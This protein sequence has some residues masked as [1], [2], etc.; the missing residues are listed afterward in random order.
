MHRPWLRA[1][2]DDRHDGAHVLRAV[3]ENRLLI[4]RELKRPRFVKGRLRFT[5][6]GTLH[7]LRFEIHD[8]PTDVA[9][10]GDH[11]DAARVTV[12]VMH[13]HGFETRDSFDV[14]VEPVA[15]GAQ[16]LQQFGIGRQLLVDGVNL[17]GVVNG[18]A[19]VR[20]LLDLFA[21]VRDD[22]VC[23]HIE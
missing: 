5:F 19:E 21:H 1:V 10:L 13:E 2:D 12:L 15:P 22:A 18:G 16:V 14:R 8:G 17:A 7:L 3:R 23:E 20:R 9:Q 4:S 6:R 11:I